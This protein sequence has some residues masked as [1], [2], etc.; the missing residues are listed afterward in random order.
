MSILDPL[1]E[2]LPLSLENAHIR[3][4]KTLLPLVHPKIRIQRLT[5]STQGGEEASLIVAGDPSLARYLLGRFFQ[6]RPSIRSLGFVPLRG[7]SFRLGAFFEH[8]DLILG[9][10]PRRSAQT[11][12]TDQVL[13]VPEWV[14]YACF[15]D[16][17][18]C[19]H[20]PDNSS[21]QSDLR[22]IRK[23]GL[24]TRVTHDPAELRFFIHSMYRPYM[25]KRFG[26]MDL[27]IK[28][29]TIAR[30]FRHGGLQLAE[31][32]HGPMAGEVFST[33]ASTVTSFTMGAREDKPEAVQ[34]GALGAL[35]AGSF[36]L[37]D[38]LGSS[39]LNF[40]GCR[41][42]LSDGVTR[43]K[44]KWGGRIV[45]REAAFYEFVISWKR[46]SRTV[47]SFLN[48]NP[49]LFRTETGFSGVWT[50]SREWF[51]HPRKFYTEVRSLVVN[52]VDRICIGVPRDLLPMPE[53]PAQT[54]FVPLEELTPQLLAHRT[55]R[56]TQ[57]DCSPHFS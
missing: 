46:M 17:E 51:A 11:L 40:G 20:I 18:G 48:S 25:K 8:G 9:V 6:G 30:R 47:R 10:V 34:R 28:S 44:R 55:R 33:T 36:A 56:C 50:P 52:G 19:L 14:D 22:R 1:L 23:F 7:L 15:R 37:A 12:S 38:Q 32:A 3:V 41:P 31:S 26:S 35:Y 29:T 53:G 4:A 42:V 49:L 13:K 54:S 5:G 27:Q 57:A 24:T 43:Y 2:R 45:H 21:V 39:C 16:A